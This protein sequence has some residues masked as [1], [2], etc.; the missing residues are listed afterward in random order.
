MRKLFILLTL[1]V[2][3]V[4]A[5]EVS[6]PLD[7]CIKWAK[8]NYPLI[9]Q[10]QLLADNSANNLKSI[11]E[12]WYPK[13]SFLA[14]STYQ[15][16]VVSFNFPGTNYQ[17]PH[18]SYLTNISLDQTI[19][20]GGQTAQ[21]KKIE[22]LNADAEIQKNEVELYKL[23]ERINNLYVNI[24]LS[25]E[26]IRILNVY[27]NDLINK[28]KNLVASLDNGLALQSNLDEL[29]AE[30]LKTDQS[31][32]ETTENLN[33]LYQALSLFIAKPIDSLSVFSMSPVGGTMPTVNIA[34]PEL[35]LLTIQQEL[36][37]SR[38]ALT[39]KMALP[40]ISM[41]VGA[42]YGRPGPNFINQNLRFFG[43]ASL[44]I[45]WNMSSLYGLNK[46][47]TKYK[48][49][50]QMLDIQREL[51]LFNLKN[52][53]IAQEA[54]IKALEEVIT[55]DQQIIQK[56]HNVTLTAANQLENG[57]IT[58]TDY[59]TQLNAEMQATLNQKIH[60]VKLMNAVSTYNTSK[61]INQF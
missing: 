36:L 42:N 3:F 23:I 52:A 2:R 47:K 43:D 34:R 19:Y 41:G 49:N 7:S 57:K 11:N 20:D 4:N 39:T 6:I 54:Q 16:E 13:L 53:F 56:R 21:Q 31:I 45:K 28:R 33:G 17:F 30:G 14:K 38:Y 25:R 10:N 37:N 35:K 40:R 18:D 51:F 44:S 55:K 27:K 58:V 50:N 48:L 9:K 12:N 24:L 46:E 15:S 26:N 1:S 61:G 5:Q 22:K 32:I 29:E 59:L 60:E 8:K